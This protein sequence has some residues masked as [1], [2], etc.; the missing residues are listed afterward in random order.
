MPLKS[1]GDG[2]TPEGYLNAE[3]LTSAGPRW[4]RLP[5]I[6]YLAESR[7]PCL[8]AMAMFTMMRTQMKIMV[9]SDL[10]R[11]QRVRHDGNVLVRIA[12]ANNDS[13]EYTNA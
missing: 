7:P 6:S 2:Q 8:D 9:Y 3:G 10:P 11:I 13:V 12:G 4:H 5:P 1:I